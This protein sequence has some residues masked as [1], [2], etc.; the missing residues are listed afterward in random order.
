VLRRRAAAGREVC[1]GGELPPGCDMPT[2]DLADPCVLDG[3]GN[4][5][6][7]EGTFCQTGCCEP[8]APG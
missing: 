4:S 5:D 1:F 8:I 2:C 6:C 3:E 7:P